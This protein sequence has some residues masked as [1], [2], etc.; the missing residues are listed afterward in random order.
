LLYR[1]HAVVAPHEQANIS[2]S[3]ANV[4]A[5]PVDFEGPSRRFVVVPIAARQ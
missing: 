2:T 3:A 1:L 4:S 5:Y